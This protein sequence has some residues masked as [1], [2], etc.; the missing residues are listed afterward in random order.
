MRDCGYET[1][2][3]PFKNICFANRGE[4][5]SK[6]LGFL[7]RGTGVPLL[8]YGPE[9]CGKTTLLRYIVWRAS[10]LGGVAVY[11][12]A[13][14]GDSLEE[15]L[16]PLTTVFKRIAGQVI[17]HLAP[18]G[19]VLAEKI[20]HFASRV[21]EELEVKERKVFIVVDDVYQA[22]GLERAEEYAKRL[23]ELQHRLYSAGASSTVIVMATSEGVSRR[24]LSRHTYTLPL[25]VWNMDYNGFQ[26]LLAQVDPPLGY[27]TL[28]RLSGGN[29]RALSQLATLEWDY[30]LWVRMVAEERIKPLVPRVGLERLEKLVEDPDSD[31]EAAAILEDYNVMMRLSRFSSLSKPPKPDPEQGIGVEW[32]WQVPVLRLAAKHVA[33]QGHVYSL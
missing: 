1:V 25:M 21:I 5:V 12:N 2:L 20:V 3:P 32:A 26:D 31:P 14:G 17:G 19:R 11:I 27:D 22:L 13:L 30:R 4:E 10:R 9:G 7:E 28:W 8:V 24:L 16:Y 29:P 23:Y 33:G 18:A 6:L 15:S